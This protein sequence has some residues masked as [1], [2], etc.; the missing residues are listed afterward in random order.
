MRRYKSPD[1]VLVFDRIRK[2]LD[3]KDSYDEFYW[4]AREYPRCYRFH[5]DG[6]DFR[7][8]S[9]HALM[10]DIFRGLS[11]TAESAAGRAALQFNV[12][13]VRVQQVYWDFE[14]YL[15]EINISLDIL[16]RI[17]GPT[18]RQQTP[19]SFNRLCKMG[20]AHP[21]LD[22]FRKAQSM[23]VRRLKD[24]RDCFVHYTPVDTRLFVSLDRCVKGWELRAPL[25]V[26]P[27][28]REILGFRYR[29][30]VELLRYAVTLHRHLTALDKA[31]ALAIW[32]L[33]RRQEFPLRREHLFF[34]G[35]RES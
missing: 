34:V 2:E 27:N 4:F 11:E 30:R 1:V 15:S 23:W 5:L 13:D 32:R 6:A 8:R 12:S 29:R 35:Q 14:S 24:Y 16:A 3:G 18:F 17:I 33:Y 20:Q 21:I 9:I 25:P 26:N 19:P 7:L 10:D 22:L 31:V 28:V